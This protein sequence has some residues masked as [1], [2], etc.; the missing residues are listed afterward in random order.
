MI[1]SLLALA[2]LFFGNMVFSQL[3]LDRDIW[4]LSHDRQLFILLMGVNT[5]VLF[6]ATMKDKL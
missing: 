2:E 4:I 1:G 5:I 3:F 6:Y